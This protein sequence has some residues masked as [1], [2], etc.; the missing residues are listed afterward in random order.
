M[1]RFPLMADG[2]HL[3]DSI[4]LSNYGK[5][6]LESKELSLFPLIALINLLLSIIISILFYF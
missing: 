5:G 2:L 3:L 4:N 6:K 1:L